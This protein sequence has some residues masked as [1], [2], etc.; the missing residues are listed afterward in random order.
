MI[1]IAHRLSTLK[2]CNKLVLMENGRLIA[3]GS[4]TEI[5]QSSSTFERMMQLS[6]LT[7]VD[8]APPSEA[9]GLDPKPTEANSLS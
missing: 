5:A 2:N 8:S 1:I 3:S 7:L 9:E 6:N 4:F